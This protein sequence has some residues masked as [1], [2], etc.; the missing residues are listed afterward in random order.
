MSEKSHKAANLVSAKEYA[1]KHRDTEEN[2][3]Q[4]ARDGL[5]A[6]VNTP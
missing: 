5:L 1:E 4:K 6:K 2:I 3:V